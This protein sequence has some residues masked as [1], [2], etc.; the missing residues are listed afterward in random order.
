VLNHRWISQLA[1][2]IRAKTQVEDC[3]IQLFITVDPLSSCH[4][5]E[6]MLN[7]KDFIGNMYLHLYQLGGALNMPFIE[8][9]LDDGGGHIKIEVDVN[10]KECNKGR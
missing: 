6:S 7:C 5:D 3:Q 10:Q 2:W 8:T 4:V 9:W 1:I